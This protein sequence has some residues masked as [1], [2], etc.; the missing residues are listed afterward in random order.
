MVHI[1]QYFCLHI[2]EK[3]KF[4]LE[5][6]SFFLFLFFFPTLSCLNLPASQYITKPFL[7]V[8]SN[9]LPETLTKLSLKVKEFHML[10][11]ENRF[12]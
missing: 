11:Q 12:D 10:L 4:K 8:D 1:I 3:R 6:V 2:Q 7:H 9:F 5:M